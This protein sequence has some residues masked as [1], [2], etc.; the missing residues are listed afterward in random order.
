MKICGLQKLTLIDYPK[1]VACTVFTCGCNFRCPFCHNADLVLRPDSVEDLT[2]EYFFDFLKKRQNILEGVCIT[3]GEPLLQP[4]LEEFI[5]KIK[6]LGFSIKLDTNGSRFERLKRILDSNLIDYVAMDIKNSPEKY[7]VTAGIKNLDI[8]DIKKSAGLL[9]NS[10]IDY[11]F[12]TTVVK[13]LHESDDFEKI[14]LWLRGAKSYFL[15]SFADSGNVLTEGLSAHTKEEME[16]FK[17]I[18]KK[19]IN[20]VHLREM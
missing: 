19:Y 4:D 6:N 13:E 3:G 5:L 10:N 17:D 9:M 2:E 18:L 8:T 1:K 20:N 12:R 11:E 7:P 14:G 15:Q 16:R